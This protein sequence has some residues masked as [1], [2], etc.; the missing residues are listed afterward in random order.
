MRY[1]QARYFRNSGT[2]GNP[3]VFSNSTI[4]DALK[5]LNRKNIINVLI[6]GKISLEIGMFSNTPNKFLFLVNSPYI[7]LNFISAINV[8]PLDFNV[9]AILPCDLNPLLSLNHSLSVSLYSPSTKNVKGEPSVIYN[10]YEGFK[11]DKKWSNY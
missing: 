7:N 6:P 3:L 8:H 1:V 10:Y 4:K 2:E 5:R 11:I 9:K